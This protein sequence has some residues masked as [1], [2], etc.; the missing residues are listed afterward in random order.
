MYLNEEKNFSIGNFISFKKPHSPE[1]FKGIILSKSMNRFD[2]T[3]IIMYIDK[4]IDNN[5]SL[6][7][8][9]LEKRRIRLV[10]DFTKNDLVEFFELNPLFN[11]F[12]VEVFKTFDKEELFY[13][14]KEK[15]DIF[16]NFLT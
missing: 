5:P 7:A 11:Q 14:F 2:D 1:R 15:R 9:N 8:I 13:L 16:I 12:E 3:F 10:E 6:S 4:D